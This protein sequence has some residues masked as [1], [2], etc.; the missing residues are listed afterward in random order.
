[1]GEGREFAPNCGQIKDKMREFSEVQMLDEQEA[2][3]LVSRA[4]AN[5]YYGYKKEFDRLPIEVQRV[6]GR[7]EQLREWAL[8]DVETVQSVVAS[9]FMRSY[10]SRSAR[11]KELARVPVEVRSIVNG[12]Q[13]QIKLTEGIENVLEG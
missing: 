6:V 5:G 3:A 9:N 8:M 13:N 11:D 10:R 2:W 1:M 7:P 12:L 4:C